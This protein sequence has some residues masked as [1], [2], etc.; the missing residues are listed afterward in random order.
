MLSR[1]RTTAMTAMPT[2]THHQASVMLSAML[3]EP[4][5]G[6][7]SR[8]RSKSER[9]TFGDS[10]DAIDHPLADRP[11]RCL[12]PRRQ[13]ELDEHVADVGA[14]RAFAD[15]ERLCDLPVGQP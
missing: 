6:R 3:P 15:Q 10:G 9:S 4:A 8:K 11:E 7:G 14:G 1:P 2:S 13:S 5:A 12:G